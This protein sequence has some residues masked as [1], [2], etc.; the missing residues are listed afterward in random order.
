MNFKVKN[1][2]NMP[3]SV[4]YLLY[5]QNLP[6]HS[7]VYAESMPQKLEKFSSQLSHIKL[8]QKKCYATSCG[9]IVGECS[10]G[11]RTGEVDVVWEGFSEGEKDS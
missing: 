8:I 5:A 1:S 9:H 2:Q 10:I 7:S 6:G 11:P 3:I 4:E